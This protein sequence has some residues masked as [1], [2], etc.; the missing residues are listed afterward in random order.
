MGWDYESGKNI[1]YCF[2]DNYNAFCKFHTD[3]KNCISR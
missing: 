2:S 1:E 3:V